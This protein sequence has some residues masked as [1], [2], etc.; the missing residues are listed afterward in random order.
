MEG[1]TLPLC[2]DRYNEDD[3]QSIEES[4]IKHVEYTLARS[5]YQFDDLEAYQ[6][7]AYSLRDRLILLWNDTQQ[8]FK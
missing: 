8:Y 3:V 7:T 5:R 4:I 2:A 6:A 1:L